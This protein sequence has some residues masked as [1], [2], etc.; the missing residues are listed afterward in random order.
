MFLRHRRF[1]GGLV[2]PVER[3]EVKKKETKKNIRIYIFQNK[4][5]Y[6]NKS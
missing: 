1:F 3:K 5:R 6:K 4:I 2:P